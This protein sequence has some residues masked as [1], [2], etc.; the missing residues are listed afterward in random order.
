[1]PS[2]EVQK[3]VD[4]HLVGLIGLA[5][6]V[7]VHIFLVI[8]DDLRQGEVLDEEVVKRVFSGKLQLLIDVLSQGPE[9]PLEVLDA[10]QLIL[11]VN[12][13]ELNTIRNCFEKLR[14]LMMNWIMSTRAASLVIRIFLNLK[15]FC[16]LSFS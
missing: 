2:H 16:Q 1:M 3:V 5:E 13:K 10:H 9:N 6:F 11:V 4:V 14:T 15:N 7:K 12:D 8:S